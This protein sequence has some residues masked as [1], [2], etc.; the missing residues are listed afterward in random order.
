MSEVDGAARLELQP[1]TSGKL[2]PHLAPCLLDYWQEDDSFPR[3]VL[4][5]LVD[6]LDEIV[7]RATHMPVKS[8]AV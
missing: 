2:E 7:K 1:E 3:Q 4:K 5:P 6:W 8:S